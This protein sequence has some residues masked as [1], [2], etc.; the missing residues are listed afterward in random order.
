VTGRAALVALAGIVASCGGSRSA[1]DAS[2]PGDG[3]VAVEP[4]LFVRGVLAPPE[5]Q[6]GV[7]CFYSADPTQAMLSS[8]NLDVLFAATYVPTFLVGNTAADAR[9]E[10]TGFDVTVTDGTATIGDFHSDAAGYIDGAW[11]GSPSYA[12]IAAAILDA[13]TVAAARASA[14]RGAAIHLVAHASVTGKT[15]VGAPVKS[16]AFDF[17]IDLCSGCLVS[18]PP[19]VGPTH[20]GCASPPP[21]FVS[22]P[23]IRGQDQTIDC[24]FCYASQPICRM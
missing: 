13:A 9:A 5:A 12:P 17:P 18:Y 23:C 24:R 19:D 14:P 21:S 16:I 11:A 22:P 6:L 20:A 8:G 7:A 4:S 10:L 15:V 3:G 2:A 1:L